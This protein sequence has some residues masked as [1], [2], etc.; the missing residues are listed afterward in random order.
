MPAEEPPQLFIQAWYQP[1]CLICKC[2]LYSNI[3]YFND[4]FHI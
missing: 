2:V 3:L 1:S 4:Y